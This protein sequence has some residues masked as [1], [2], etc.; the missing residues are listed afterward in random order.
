MTRQHRQLLKG[1]AMHTLAPEQLLLLTIFGSTQMR[2]YVNAELDRRAAAQV[3]YVHGVPQPA[4]LK[5]A[6]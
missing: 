1:R 5:P 6:A 3:K 4:F 2:R